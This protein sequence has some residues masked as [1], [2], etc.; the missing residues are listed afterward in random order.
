MQY[1]SQNRTF[2]SKPTLTDTQV[3]EFCKQGYL[4]LE[5][6]VPQKVN[7]KVSKYLAKKISPNPSYIPSHLTLEML[8]GTLDSNSPEP[9]IILLEDWFINE[10]LLN[11]D[12]AGVLRS[13]LGKNVG[14]PVL[15][16]KHS[17]ECPQP[18]QPWH[19][20][21][22]SLFGPEVNYL[23]IFY[24]PQDTPIE[25]GPTDVVP[26]SHIGLNKF[27]NQADE[28][29]IATVAP[30]G[31]FVLHSQS[32]FHRRGRSTGTGIRYMLKYKYWRTTSPIRDWIRQPEFDFA[33]ADYG[34]HF[35]GRYYA[36][37]FYWLCGKEKDFKLIGGQGWP[38][39]KP[40]QIAPSY[41]YNA[42][43]GYKPDWT[44]LHEQCNCGVSFTGHSVNSAYIK[45]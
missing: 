22:D 34:G 40:N 30:A 12:L 2:D 43:D 36:H 23:E 18:A 27:H 19:H 44:R 28:F 10:V 39:N 24:Y 21:S 45:C 35:A 29:S 16:S 7:E 5:G 17:T 32:I 15:V 13:L 31:S 9:N 42:Q 20:E 14:L 6:V 1:N 38:W 26:G 3:L 33:T 41:G 25:M 37:M 11:S 4:I 8:K